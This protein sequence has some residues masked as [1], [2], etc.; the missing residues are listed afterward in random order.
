MSNEVFNVFAAIGIGLTFLASLAAIVVSIVSQKYSNRLAERS[1]YLETITAGRDK[2]SNSLRESASLYFTQIARICDG[3]EENLG[4]IYN[5]FIHYHFAIALLLFEQ[6]RKINDDMCTVRNKA[7]EI[8][9]QSNIIK[10][11][12][13]KLNE[14]SDN[15]DACIESQKIV[16]RAQQK[17]YASRYEILNDYQGRIFEGIR[18]LLENEWRKQQHEATE[19]WNEKSKQ[20]LGS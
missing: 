14:C 7:F 9:E 12:Y 17:M 20:I 3:Q 13:E 4:E 11:Q 2:W 6:D 10:Q 19:M 18:K 8:V 15:A 1:G 5:E 16:I